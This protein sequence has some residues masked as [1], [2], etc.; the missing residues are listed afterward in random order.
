MRLK[1]LIIHGFKSFSNRT[2]LHF[3]GAI[4]S[5]VGPNGCGKSNV[6][7]AIRWALGE[8]SAKA[9]RGQGMSDIIFAGTDKKPPMG[10]AE[11]TMV[12]EREQG[13]PPPV[14]WLDFPE[15]KVGRIL[16][17][18][19]SSEYRLQNLPCRLKD[20]VEVFLGTGLGA[21]T[22]SII[23]QGKISSLIASR[24]Q[25]RRILF[26]EAAKITRYKARHKEALRRLK[27]SRSNL[28]RIDDM[29]GELGRGV[30]SLKRQK[31][32]AVKYEEMKGEFENLEK[33]K[34]SQ[35]YS[36]LTSKVKSCKASITISTEKLQKAKAALSVENS[37]T[38]TL[39]LEKMEIDRQYKDGVEKYVSL[40]KSLNG[41]ET[42]IKILETKIKH[43]KELVKRSRKEKEELGARVI[44]KGKLI[45]QS[46]EKISH[47]GAIIKI[48]KEDL[49][50]LEIRYRTIKNDKIDIDGK[51][52]ALKKTLLE[53]EQKRAQIIAISESVKV[54][55]K[56][57]LLSIG[58]CNKLQIQLK[59][60][61]KENSLALER[62]QKSEVELLDR[63]AM[64]QKE[65]ESITDQLLKIRGVKKEKLSLQLKMREDLSRISGEKSYLE[66]M[67]NHHK[68]LNQG[69]KKLIEL[70]V[71]KGLMSDTSGL[72]VDEVKPQKRWQ[73]A[74]EAMISSALGY[75][76]ADNQTLAMEI[77]DLAR[78]NSLASG[79]ILVDGNI[80][81]EKF[82]EI[83]ENNKVVAFIDGF[84][85]Y[86]PRLE[87][88][89]HG[90]Y[91]VEDMES[92]FSIYDK[93][94]LHG[95]VVT[96]DGEVVSRRGVVTLPSKKDAGAF[97]LRSKLEDVLKKFS[98]LTAV[99]STLREELTVLEGK[100][101]ILI[102]KELENRDGFAKTNTEYE[103]FKARRA[104]LKNDCILNANR[105]KINSDRLEGL[106]KELSTLVEDKSSGSLEKIS[107]NIDKIQHKIWKLED[108]ISVQNELLLHVQEEVGELKVAVQNWSGKLK[109]EKDLVDILNLELQET[110]D[111]KAELNGQITKSTQ[112]LKEY[113]ESIAK[114]RVVSF[115]IAKTLLD[116][117]KSQE[118]VSVSYE[119]MSQLLEKCKI[120]QGEKSR[121]IGR[122]REQHGLLQIEL[123]KF[124]S[125]IS[126]MEKEF[127]GK[128][129]YEIGTTLKSLDEKGVYGV[130]E[131]E[132]RES[133]S[134]QVA[135]RVM[136]YNPN[137]IRDFDDV[138]KRHL[139]LM[140]QKKELM[141]AV[142]N[143]ERAI[144]I[145]T[146]TTRERFLAA[147]K[148]ISNKFSLLFPKLFNGGKAELNLSEGDPLEAGVEIIA[149]PPG[150]KLQSMELLSGGEKAMI[151]IA[152]VFSLFLYNPSPFC[153]LDEVD[154]PL[155]ESNVEKYNELLREMSERTQFIV[156]THNR[157]TMEASDMLFGVTMEEPGVSRAVSLELD[158]VDKFSQG[159][160]FGGD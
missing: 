59:S 14:P 129:G 40:E 149:Q 154:A 144:T 15:I 23:E 89:F 121:D 145:I 136:E 8:Q 125:N 38:Q 34:F 151:S 27:D 7:D 4:T 119:K 109:N 104:E 70:L 100:E 73:K 11:V 140:E 26:E 16:H 37:K 127:H 19:G 24:P 110:D 36:E 10:M 112:E 130:K 84:E 51:Y 138:S 108:K 75:P 66:D 48:K 79:V 28:D 18:D 68:D 92:A 131:E 139:Y 5:V 21:R 105:N 6:V 134:V 87:K 102:Q 56:S 43:N 135:K 150:K 115:D 64:F 95:G 33:W 29:I 90:W 101:R 2:V 69:D 132:R 153:I 141:S 62:W 17:R 159:Q 99:E 52:D 83:V 12:F 82:P 13:E 146:N 94:P 58:E 3:P 106:E 103:K 133:L 77:I 47:F 76:L 63:L 46:E 137:A 57:L 54:R 20:I 96:A 22:Y 111:K 80:H 32:A 74:V 71:K 143:L 39:Q 1:R 107:S 44:R 9:L 118:L 155:D 30:N 126:Y 114:T 72:F 116:H 86:N 158:S 98:S 160:L 50:L 88:L 147:F 49:Q 25:E 93:L 113:E 61:E 67:V 41:E 60:E 142:K 65:T 78:Q 148:D 31:D 124:E 35:N 81:G 53:N 152:L 97:S 45:K 122:V 85:S 55:K 117:K 157:L 91:F 123:S 42:K 156:I 120:K 128:Y